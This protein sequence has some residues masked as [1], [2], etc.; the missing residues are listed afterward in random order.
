MTSHDHDFSGQTDSGNQVPDLSKAEAQMA[1]NECFEQH[2]PVGVQLRAAREA[3]G[4]SVEDAGRKLRLPARVLRQLEADDFTGIDSPIYLRGYLRSYSGLL[5][6]KLE[7]MPTVDQQVAVQPLPL[8]TTGGV[9]H[10][11]YLLQRYAVA[12]TYLVITALIVVPILVLGLNGGLNRDFARLAPLDIEPSSAQITADANSTT[13]TTSTDTS[14]AGPKT[15]QPLR[16]SMAPF[17]LLDSTTAQSAAPATDAAV[18]APIAEP[19]PV[20]AAGPQL[21]IQ[22]VAPSWVEVI[23]SA[24]TRLEYALLP[25]GEYRYSSELALKVLLGDSGSAKVRWNGEALNLAPYQ[26]GNRAYFQVD[27]GSGAVSD[28]DKA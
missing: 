12:S 23:D 20:A 2:N 25:A 17:L 19:V 3:L 28:P 13:S 18:T 11:R 15:E 9:S 21:R 8:V 4:L 7:S 27:A 16:A 14:I 1:N 26:S 22:L 6:V 10:G 5:G 24:G